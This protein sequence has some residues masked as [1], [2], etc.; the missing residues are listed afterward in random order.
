MRS[1]Q[2]RINCVLVK[3]LSRFGRDYIQTGYYIQHFF[4]QNRIRF[5][6]I[7]ERY[8]S[9][10]VDFW[11]RNLYLPILNILND[12]YCQD[13]SQKVRLGQESKGKKV[14]IQVLFVFM[15]IK[16][17]KRITMC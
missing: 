14:P 4:P 15:A 5:I 13:I 3:D 16:K 1:R 10:Q 11:E 12:G 17:M 8:D 9:I 6:A 2:G 7:S